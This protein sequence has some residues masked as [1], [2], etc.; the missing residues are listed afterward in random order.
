MRIKIKRFSRTADIVWALVAVVI[1]G[2]SSYFVLSGR[3][4]WNHVVL[5]YA[6][7]FLT[8]LA[9]SAT[10]FVPAPNLPAIAIHAHVLNPVLTALVG[11]LGWGLGE[12]TGYLAGRAGRLE[13]RNPHPTLY[14]YWERNQFL[15]VL[16]FAIVPNPLFDVI[17]VL[18]GTARMRLGSFLLA[19]LI[20]RIT[21]AII[22]AGSTVGISAFF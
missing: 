3:L 18:A 12:I 17:G 14:R 7:L 5:G 19:T 9:G 13:I 4:S 1:A 21:L 2:V 10:I 22:V 16:A 15:T 8:T 20:G 11:G 6:G